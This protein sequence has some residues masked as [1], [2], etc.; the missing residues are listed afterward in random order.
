MDNRDFKLNQ[1]RLKK[2]AKLQPFPGSF[3]VEMT[4]E[5]ENSISSPDVS[6]NQADPNEAAA[7]E[8]AQGKF[9]EPI[10]LM[11]AMNFF[12]DGQISPNP[13]TTSTPVIPDWQTKYLELHAYVMEVEESLTR[14]KSDF[15][16]RIPTWTR[17]LGKLDALEITSFVDVDK[18]KDL[19]FLYHFQ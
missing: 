10:S 16:G 11:D 14:L 13:P 1:E 17:A 19:S 9:R 12:L 4:R 7:N 3:F 15:E 18:V 5:V 2:W 8:G 6:A